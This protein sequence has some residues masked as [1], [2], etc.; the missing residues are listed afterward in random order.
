MQRLR[1]DELPIWYKDVEAIDWSQFEYIYNENTNISELFSEI[2]LASEPIA[3]KAVGTLM[4][5]IEHQDW[6]LDAACQVI[7]FFIKIIE[8]NDRPITVLEYIAEGLCILGTIIAEV[9]VEDMNFHR[10]SEKIS[11]R[12]FADY[13]NVLILLEKKYPFLLKI[14][15]AKLS[16][17]ICQEMC[18]LM[19][20][21]IIW[22]Q[23]T[24]PEQT[25]KYFTETRESF[26]NLLQDLNCGEHEKVSI[27]A[28]M[29]PLAEYDT[30]IIQSLRDWSKHSKEEAWIKRTLAYE[31]SEFQQGRF[32]ST[33]EK[34][35]RKNLAICF[36]D[37]HSRYLP[38]RQAIRINNKWIRRQRL[39]EELMKFKTM[40]KVK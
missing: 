20:A 12:L 22:K 5:E 38:H 27:I 1:T 39:K 11:R 17:F 28:S 21:L 8:D 14:F 4:L 34:I 36:V 7:P 15:N 30:T 40:F 26:F 37:G 13:N 23:K 19:V 16:C 25:F 10:T 31:I 24:S 6:T 32:A 2:L 33:N 29:M 9:T 3:I 18:K 35:L